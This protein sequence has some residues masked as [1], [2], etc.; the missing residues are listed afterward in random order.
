LSFCTFSFDHCVI[1][2]S[3]FWAYTDSDYS[4]GIFKLFPVQMLSILKSSIKMVLSK[5]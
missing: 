2:S 3:I 1:C 5:C 4:F